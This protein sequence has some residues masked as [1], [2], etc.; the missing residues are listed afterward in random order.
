VK[1]L[2]LAVLVLAC[3]SEA[4]A[5]VAAPEQQATL[6]VKRYVDA[7][8]AEL[9]RSTQAICA[10]APEP[11]ADG[12]SLESDRERVEAMRAAWRRSR[13]AYERV[14]GA[15]AI[16][17][18][19]TDLAIDSRYEHVVE[20]R[21]DASPF[22][23]EGF[24]GLHA[25]E[26]ILWSSSI[27]PAVDRFERA[28]AHYT[29]PRTPQTEAEARA[30]REQLCARLV[31]DVHAMEQS[32]APIALDPATAWRGIV[33]SV[34]EQVEKVLLG[35]TGQ[36]ES[37]Y[38]G[39][40][41]AD[42]RANLEGGRAVLAAFAPMIEAHPP[43]VA[44]RAQI[45]ARLVALEHAYRAAGENALP[46]VPDGFDPDAPTEAALATPYGRLFDLLSTASDP[47]TEG[48][49][50]AMLRQTGQDMGIAPL[51]R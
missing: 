40:T 45:E 16:L 11:D 44:R 39:T 51:A 5:P 1:R 14:E 17:F 35:A 23:G 21:A 31:R 8:V 47:L 15:I 9:S 7:Q 25:I 49:L 20:L 37:R 29:P 12:W 24:V 43:C 2:L 26:R 32:L 50:A 30:F 6:E 19:E 46:A 13:A 4:P 42:M 34:E 38:A 18:P 41:L 48:S 3:G 33:G 22:D 28:L 36:D 27:S 10:A